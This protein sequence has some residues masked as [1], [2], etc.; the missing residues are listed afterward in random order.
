MDFDVK[1]YAALRRMLV[2]VAKKYAAFR[3]LLVIFSHHNKPP[4]PE[5]PLNLVPTT[6]IPDEARLHRQLTNSHLK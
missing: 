4:K 6:P 3:H 1:K 5:D 2:L